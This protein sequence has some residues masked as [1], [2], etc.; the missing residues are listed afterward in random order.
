M[1]FRDTFSRELVDQVLHP[2]LSIKQDQF[3]TCSAASIQYQ[4]A[5]TK[6][7]IRKRQR[8]QSKYYFFDCGVKRALEGAGALRVPL[9]QLGM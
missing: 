7:A 9:R 6:P 8:L 3:G 2:H 1:N 5:E 4:W